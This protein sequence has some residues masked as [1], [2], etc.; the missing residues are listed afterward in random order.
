MAS[1][2]K[3]IRILL[4]PRLY[5][6][7]INQRYLDL[8]AEACR[9]VCQ[10][11]KRLHTKI[12]LVY[13]SVSLQTVFLAGL[14]LVYC[15]WH[16]FTHTNTFKSVGALT[17]CSI[18]LYVMTERWPPSRKYRDLFEVVKTS[19]LDAIAEGKHM[20]RTAVKSLKDDMQTSFQNGGLHVDFAT[21]S[22]SDDLEQM[23][24]DITGEQISFWDDI[25]MSRLEEAMYLPPV[26][27]GS[28][29]F[30]FPQ[31]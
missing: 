15:M 16:D 26:N 20:P 9:S 24:S 29:Q 17:D 19:V 1:Y 22:L 23:I 14:T 3:A 12:P 6:S 31:S 13:S 11:Y 30:Y 7:A 10:V 4:Q 21:E 8:C 5:E 27:D 2:H 25:N 18:I 28:Q